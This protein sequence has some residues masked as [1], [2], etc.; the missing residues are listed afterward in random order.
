MKALVLTSALALGAI[1]V[2]YPLVIA[3]LAATRRARRAAPGARP[4]VTV[5]IATRDDA[6]TVRRRVENALASA[7][8]PALLDVVVALDAAGSAVQPSELAD[9]GGRVT[10]VAGDAPGGKAS[11]LNAGVRAAGGEVLVFGDA[12]QLFHPDAVAHLVDALAEPG[13]AAASG[14]LV[15]DGH[16]GPPTLADRYWRY[17]TWLRE[18]EALVH[19]TVGVSGAIY[20]MKAPLWRALPAGLILDD[21]YGPMSL[22]L[23]G[24]RVGFVRAAKAV[25]VRRFQPQQEYRRKA[26]T[27]TGNLQLCAWLPGVLVPVR[28]PIWL[29]FV[30]HKLARLAT[31][32]LALAVALGALVLGARALGDALPAALLG[33]ALA[34]G[35]LMAARPSL[36]RRA[37]HLI[38]WGVA[39]Q[40]AVVVATFNGLRGRWDVWQR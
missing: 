39:L 38:A 34:V 33:V 23:R 11:A 15:V 6:A 20:G 9:L 37:G 40:A 10:I 2:G 3:A 30:C 16:G 8:D 22:V 29:Q 24:H 32:Y 12:H 13:V 21:V 19:S 35:L 25:E 17:E 26:R 27:L 14:C 31:P 5:V 1:W 18:N 4:S 36:R 7:Y 28:N